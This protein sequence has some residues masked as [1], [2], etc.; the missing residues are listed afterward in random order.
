M[1]AGPRVLLI[2]PCYRERERLPHFLPDLCAALESAQLPVRV[3]VVDDGSGAAE[4]VWLEEY[5]DDLRRS[6]RALLDAAQ[7]NHANGGKGSAVYA[8]WARAEGATLLGF[9]D[10]D[11]AVPALEVVRLVQLALAAP[12]A[13]TFAVRTGEN[14]TRVERTLGR[15]VAGQVFRWLVRG[16]FGFPLP[17]TQCG[18]K[19]VPAT[20]WQHFAD[21][22]SE[23]RFTFDVELVW[24]LLR[25]GTPVTAVP[26]HWTESPGSRLRPVSVLAMVR[27]LI[28][29]RRRLGA[30]QGGA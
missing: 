30:W 21:A 9:V 29:L 7:L 16:L 25:R 17:D 27:S 14:G 8:G 22:L 12:E 13:A 10:A 5:V 26:I 28:S 19:L 11:G 20:A 1:M 6:G 15:R 18:F 3:R 2:I 4:A 23:R 24:H